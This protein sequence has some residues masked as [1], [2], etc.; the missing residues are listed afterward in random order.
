MTATVGYGMKKPAND[1]QHFPRVIAGSVRIG[2]F[3]AADAF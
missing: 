2:P 1:R 3:T